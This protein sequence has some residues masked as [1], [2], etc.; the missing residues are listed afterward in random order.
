MER[1]KKRGKEDR[2][3]REPKDSSTNLPLTVANGKSDLS[4]IWSNNHANAFGPSVMLVPQCTQKH[5]T[6]YW[7]YNL[8]AIKS[9][10]NPF[11]STVTTKCH[12]L[13][14]FSI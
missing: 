7:L 9:I 5:K 3:G 1:D 12:I 11:Q 13:H 14:C 4:S 2:R 6:S 10:Q 8:T